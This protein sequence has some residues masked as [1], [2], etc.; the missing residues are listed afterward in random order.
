MTAVGP[1]G[2]GTVERRSW[3]SLLPTLRVSACPA[4]SRLQHHMQGRCPR[5]DYVWPALCSK[6]LTWVLVVPLGSRT[7][8]EA[9]LQAALSSFES[10]PW[11]R[12]ESS[13]QVQVLTEHRLVWGLHDLQADIP[14]QGP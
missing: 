13:L 2:S 1:S 14:L 4:L 8:V 10:G 11:I 9:Q 7:P 6:R 5:M 3:L 12:A